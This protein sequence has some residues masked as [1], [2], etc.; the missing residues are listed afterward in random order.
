LNG[1][2]YP[3]FCSSHVID[4]NIDNG[5]IEIDVKDHEWI[6]IIDKTANEI[7]NDPARNRI[8]LN[9]QHTGFM[10]ESNDAGALGCLGWAIEKHLDVIPSKLRPIFQKILD[11]TKVKKENLER[12]VDVM[13]LLITLRLMDM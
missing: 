9:E 11:N 13:S 10:L 8:K 1:N 2:N 5:K 7:C 12:H 4:A 3:S 6:E